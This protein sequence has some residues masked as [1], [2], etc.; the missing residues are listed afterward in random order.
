M[1]EV[2]DSSADVLLIGETIWGTVLVGGFVG[3]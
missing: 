1:D 3:F 2:I